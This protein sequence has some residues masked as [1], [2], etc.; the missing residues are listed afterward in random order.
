MFYRKTRQNNLFWILKLTFVSILIHNG[1]HKKIFAQF[2][3]FSPEVKI[4]VKSVK[5]YLKAWKI[6]E[7]FFHPETLNY[8]NC[9]ARRASTFIFFRI[10]VSLNFCKT[11]QCR[12]GIAITSKINHPQHLKTLQKLCG[13][14]L[15][16]CSTFFFYSSKTCGSNQKIPLSYLL[17]KFV[18]K[19]D[20]LHCFF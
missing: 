5:K 6:M 16:Q 12:N 17:K 20:C 10:Y 9:S 18:K 14:S 7:N 19:I 13:S 3:P 15:Q 8:G 2:F 4:L 1:S 11:A